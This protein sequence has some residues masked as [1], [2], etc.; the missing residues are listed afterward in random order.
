MQNIGNKS[1]QTLDA[2]E[3]VCK[4]DQKRSQN[5]R[6]VIAKDNGGFFIAGIVDNNEQNE[7]NNDRV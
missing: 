5:D 2:E 4:C 1:R 7:R 6:Y 3:F